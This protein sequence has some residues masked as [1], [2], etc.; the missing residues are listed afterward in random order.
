V[1]ALKCA[2][3]ASAVIVAILSTVLS[4]VP[5]NATDRIVLRREGRELAVEGKVLVE[6]EDG[7]L[8]VMAR[9]GSL[10]AIQPDEIQ[11]HSQD[12]EP[13]SPLSKAELG[14]RLL[15]EMPPGFKIHATSHYVICYNTSG[16]YAQ[17]CGAL[18]ERLYRAFETYWSHQRLELQEPEFP[19]CALLFDSQESYAAHARPL[20][21]EAAFS[22]KGYYHLASNRV[23]MYDL[24]GVEGPR[25]A[26]EAESTAAHIT[27]LLS[28]PGA[29]LNVATI[30]HEATH[31]LAYNRGLYSRSAKTPLWASE[32]LAVYF[33]QPDLKSSRGWRTIGAVNRQRL[34]AFREYLPRR[35]ADSL[36][37]LVASDA[38]FTDPKVA[39]A[40][41]AEAWALHYFLLKSR[42]KEYVAYLES[43]ADMEPM[44]DES[45][46]ER[47]A[48]F[49]SA[50][51]DLAKLDAEFVR[52][53]QRVR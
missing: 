9:D 15:A 25:G 43:L 40:A 35:G 19:L 8:L 1:K 31:Q 13:F 41:Y 32:G 42:S 49:Q 3:S 51:G 39:L 18:F 12:D 6:A 10:W 5:A 34:I 48:R 38:R 11:E 17:W 33:E 46:D 28:E 50:F 14:E 37:T 26:G 27:R 24:T 16:A 44:A 30:I 47:L 7:G 53:M 52:F 4:A 23:I 29:E 22:I 20:L 36:A 45:E 2:L 21:G